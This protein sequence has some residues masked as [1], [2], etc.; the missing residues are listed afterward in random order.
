MITPH[1]ITGPQLRV[2]RESQHLSLMDV[3]DLLDGEAAQSTIHRWEKSPEL[4]PIWAAE[5]LLGTTEITL[6]LAELHALLDYAQARNLN[7]S[8]LLALAI[9][10]HI[11]RHEPTALQPPPG[12][13]LNEDIPIFHDTVPT[14]DEATILQLAAEAAA[15]DAARQTGKPTGKPGK[16]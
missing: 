1:S 6:P 9:R 10:E 13:S 11:A 16:P 4:I 12:L 14:D 7:F 3:S 5:K 2:W 15:R 8:Q